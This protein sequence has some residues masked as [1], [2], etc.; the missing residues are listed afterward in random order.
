MIRTFFGLALASAMGCSGFQV[1]GPLAKHYESGKTV[2]PPSAPA[3]PITVPAVKPTPPLSIVTPD[4]VERDP[5]LAA[6]KLTTEF[7][8]DRGTIS[9]APVTAEVSR[10]KGGVKQ[11]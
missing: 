9:K 5:Y 7:E 4:E 3:E 6:Q 8:T 2:L 10:Y 11:R 1:I